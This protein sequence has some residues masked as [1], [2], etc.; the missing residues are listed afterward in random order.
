MAIVSITGHVHRDGRGSAS[1]PGRHDG[2]GTRAASYG[3][4][5]P[6]PSTRSRPSSPAWRPKRGFGSGPYDDSRGFTDDLLRHESCHFY[7]PSANTSGWTGTWPTGSPRPSA[8]G[9]CAGVCVGRRTASSLCGRP[10]MPSRSPYGS[11]SSTRPT[12]SG[13]TRVTPQFHAMLGY[14]GSG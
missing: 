1:V 10:S 5:S 12:N 11:S 2:P 6:T 3:G 9:S 13:A 7:R 4:R 8:A 14:P